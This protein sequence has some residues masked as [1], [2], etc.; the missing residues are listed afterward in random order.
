MYV[1]RYSIVTLFCLFVCL[2]VRRLWKYARFMLGG[3]GGERDLFNTPTPPISFSSL[4]LPTYLPT[5]LLY[6]NET[7]QVGMYFPRCLS[8]PPN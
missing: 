6:L 1:G 3:D 7:Y 4:I 8:Y 2:F 5:Y